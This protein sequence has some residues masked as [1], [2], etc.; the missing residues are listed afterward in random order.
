MDGPLFARPNAGAS[1][2]TPGTPGGAHRAK[3]AKKV[4]K[5]ARIGI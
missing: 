2:D 4:H 1:F 3:F 5:P